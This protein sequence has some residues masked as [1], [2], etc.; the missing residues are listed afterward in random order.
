MQIQPNARRIARLKAECDVSAD[1][2]LLLALGCVLLV[3]WLF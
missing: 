2:A 3:L 1:T